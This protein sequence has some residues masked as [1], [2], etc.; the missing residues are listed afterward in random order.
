MTH[1]RPHAPATHDW[2]VWDV[3]AVVVPEDEAM[4]DYLSMIWSCSSVSG[5]ISGLDFEF[6]SPVTVPSSFTGSPSPSPRWLL[7]KVR[8]SNFVRNNLKK[9]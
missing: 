5:E 2:V 4:A 3:E 7:T 9:N 6:R 1:D 8:F